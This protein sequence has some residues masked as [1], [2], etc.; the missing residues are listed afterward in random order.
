MSVGGKKKTFIQDYFN[1]YGSQFRHKR[2][3]LNQGVLN[4]HEW[5]IW[6]NKIIFAFLNHLNI[7]DLTDLNFFFF[8]SVYEPS[9]SIENFFFG[10]LF[11]SKIFPV[12]KQTETYSSLNV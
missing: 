11:I 7:Y 1:N 9:I 4:N 10:A 8:L 12:S 5:M 2:G 3:L 6:I